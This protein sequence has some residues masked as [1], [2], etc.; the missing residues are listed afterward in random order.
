[1]PFIFNN[2][3]FHYFTIEYHEN[4]NCKFVRINFLNIDT[5]LLLV[6]IKYQIHGQTL[7]HCLLQASVKFLICQMDFVSFKRK[8][9][10][11]VTFFDL[12]TVQNANVWYGSFFFYA[13]CIH[14]Q[15]LNL[16]VIYHNKC[17]KFTSVN[18]CKTNGNLLNGCFVIVSHNFQF[19][20]FSK[21]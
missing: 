7:S 18:K 2:F 17:Y 1:M 6:L 4:V 12:K 14:Y 19:I 13:F 3:S 9:T 5:T 8:S 15:F 10:K 21:L 11:P 16:G 20:Q